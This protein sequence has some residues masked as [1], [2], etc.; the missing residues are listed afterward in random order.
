ML[1]L[2]QQEF[3]SIIIGEGRNNFLIEYYENREEDQSTELTSEDW[4]SLN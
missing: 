2:V 4:A 3:M 1:E